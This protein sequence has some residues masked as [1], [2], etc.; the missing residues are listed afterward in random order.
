[1]ASGNPGA[2]HGLYWLQYGLVLR[3]FDRHSEALEK[4]TTAREAFTSPQI[5]H[6]FA[7]Q[8]LIIAA[9]AGAWDDAEPQL[10]EAVRTFRS[11][12]SEGWDGDTYPI[13]SLAEGHIS[14]VLRF[15]GLEVAQKLARQYGN[16]LI[17]AQKRNPNQR[18]EEAV[19]NVV[20]FATTGVW[21]ESYQPAYLDLD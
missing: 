15:Q 20:T 6:A 11:L 1:M 5:E 9:S 3:D 19:T 14:V 17:A 16:E 7:Q 13:V 10:I 21:K 18:L 12:D 2:V 4:L 8:L